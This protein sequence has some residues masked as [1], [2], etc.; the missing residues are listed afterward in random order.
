MRRMQPAL[1]RRGAGFQEGRRETQLR[2][3]AK[4]PRASRLPLF[5]T[6]GRDI[7]TG[8]IEPQPT[9]ID[10]GLSSNLPAFRFHRPGL[11]PLDFA[12][13]FFSY[14][15]GLELSKPELASLCCHGQSSS[16]EVS[17]TR[18]FPVRGRTGTLSCTARPAFRHYDELRKR[19]LLLPVKS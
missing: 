14:G 6:L 2:G 19:R 9:N 4:I 17:R 3:G 15:F 7:N 18:S 5:A 1:P 11:Q 8:F 12:H 10:S 13:Y 16:R